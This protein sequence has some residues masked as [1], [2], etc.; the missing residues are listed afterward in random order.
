MI[1]CG[2]TRW[3]RLLHLDEGARHP[4]WLEEHLAGCAKCRERMQ[5]HLDL[6]VG[7]SRSKAR[8]A[9]PPFLATRII[10]AVAARPLVPR[11]W[12]AG[13][14]RLAVPV[15][16][17]LVTVQ[18][19]NWG[20]GAWGDAYF[21]VQAPAI[22]SPADTVVL[23]AGLEPVAYKIPFFPPPVRFLRIQSYFT[24]PS[25]QTNATDR[26]MQEIVAGHRGA[27]F[28]L[29]RAHEEATAEAALAGYG[30]TQRK[31]ACQTFLPAIDPDRSQPF[32]FCPVTKERK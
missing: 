29:Y 8:L 4:Q 1:Q 2:R 24:G 10:A 11:P 12:W 30:L 28:I 9:T 19:A 23:A 14:G 15:A 31:Q 17:I 7:L 21:G 32:Y 27:L 16:L 13:L 3:W 22:A 20:R 6:G 5:A 25:A 18:P 26:R